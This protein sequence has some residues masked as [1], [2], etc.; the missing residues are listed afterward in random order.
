MRFN[1]RVGVI[2]GAAG[3]IGGATARAMAA[4]GAKL[5]LTDVRE[6]ELEQIRAEISDAGGRAVS[7][8]T[9]LADEAGI[10]GFISSAIDTWGRLDILFNGAAIVDPSFQREDR[11]IVRM[12]A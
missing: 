11:D 6:P 3:G 12:S 1:D 7:Y 4:E 2:T 8:A 5:V 10:R 9:A